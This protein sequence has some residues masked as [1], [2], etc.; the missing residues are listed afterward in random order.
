MAKRRS[1]NILGTT[2]W[3]QKFGGS[4]PGFFQEGNEYSK[5]SNMSVEAN[6]RRLKGVIRAWAAKERIHR[7]ERIMRAK[8]KEKI[9]RRHRERLRENL[10]AEVRDI[11]NLARSY[12]LEAMHKLREIFETSEQDSAKIAAIQV[13]LERAYG[14]ATQTSIN[15]NIDA[16]GKSNEV[17]SKELD[18]RITET[19]RRVESITAG[20]AKEES[21]E[22]GPTDV[23]VGDRDPGN[24]SVH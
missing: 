18:T 24:S 11:Q 10:Q 16:N 7:G 13:I 5:A 15:A 8:T 9:S 21:S 22:D 17:T 19:L 1:N 23:R 20:A 3:G 6:R 2:R 12:A 14:K 4:S